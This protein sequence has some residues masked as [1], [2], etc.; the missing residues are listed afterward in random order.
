VATLIA[1]AMQ[2]EGSIKF[3]LTAADGQI[4]KTANNAKLRRLMSEKFQF[5]PLERAIQETVTWFK[6]NYETARK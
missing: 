3:D 2:F 6:N 4:K 1:G 5:T